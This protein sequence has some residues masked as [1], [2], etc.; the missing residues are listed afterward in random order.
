MD[1]AVSATKCTRQNFTCNI[2]KNITCLVRE[3][4][5]SSKLY[6]HLLIPFI[7]LRFTFPANQIRRYDASFGQFPYFFGPKWAILRCA[8]PDVVWWPKCIFWIF[9]LTYR[10]F[11]INKLIYFFPIDAFAGFISQI[12]ILPN[13]IV[14]FGGMWCI[15][16]WYG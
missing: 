11:I 1:G 13:C 5:K 9:F 8:K 10:Y 12:N 15:L 7:L 14:I 4:G 3:M 16:A 6:H 2:K